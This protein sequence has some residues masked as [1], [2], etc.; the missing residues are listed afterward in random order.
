MC[1]EVATYL[2]IL[3]LFDNKDKALTVSYLLEVLGFN[4]QAQEKADTNANL[5]K[6]M[7]LVLELRAKARSEKDFATSDLVRDSLINAGIEIKD[8]RD[9]ASEWKLV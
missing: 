4:L 8:H 1:L 7:D 6:V 5:D 2:W 9:A 3:I